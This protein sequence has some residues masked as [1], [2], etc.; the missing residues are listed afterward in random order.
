MQSRKI[1]LSVTQQRKWI[2]SGVLMNSKVNKTSLAIVY[3]K[4]ANS[5]FR[6]S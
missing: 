4:E 1:S 5:T 2:F 6:A 3:T